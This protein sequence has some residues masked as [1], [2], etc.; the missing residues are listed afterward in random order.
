MFLTRLGFGSRIVVTG[1][2]TQVDLPGGVRSGLQVVREILSDVDDVHF[3]LLSSA[4]VVRHRLVADIVDAY[5]R[6]DASGS[7]PTSGPPP[8]ATAPRPTVAPAAAA[9]GATGGGRATSHGCRRFAS[10]A[11]GATRL[12]RCEGGPA[13]RGAPPARGR[14]PGTQARFQTGRLRSRNALRNLPPGP[15]PV[16]PR[17]S[18][19]GAATAARAAP[20]AC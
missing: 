7:A 10:C 12:E 9:L 17:R 20:A 5:A 15:R 19:E 14:P 8:R 2:V 4:D 16:R 6:W 13:A 18:R 3:A 1:D 11:R